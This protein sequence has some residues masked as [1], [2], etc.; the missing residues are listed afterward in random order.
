ML[1]ALLLADR[2]SLTRGGRGR[3]V[4]RL[5]AAEAPASYLRNAE[6]KIIVLHFCQ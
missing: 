1:E 6:R 5:H 3:H 2:L 4:A